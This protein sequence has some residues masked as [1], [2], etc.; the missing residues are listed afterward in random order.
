MS[1]RPLLPPSQLPPRR[2]PGPRTLREEYIELGE[3]ARWIIGF[4]HALNLRNRGHMAW[5][6]IA[7]R[8]GVSVAQL[9]RWRLAYAELRAE[10]RIAS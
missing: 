2:R 5:G 7:R 8:T 4:R 3:Q 1:Q 6:R 10:G 9:R